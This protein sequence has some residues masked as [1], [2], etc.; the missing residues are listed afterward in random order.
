MMIELRSWP[1]IGSM[2]NASKYS[3]GSVGTDRSSAR[4][5]SPASS[6]ADC[7]ASIAS[8]VKPGGRCKGVE[9]DMTHTPCMSG[10]PLSS[11]GGA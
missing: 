3:V 1:R 7:A 10:W 9:F 11:R 4:A 6:F 8:V 5:S 2:L